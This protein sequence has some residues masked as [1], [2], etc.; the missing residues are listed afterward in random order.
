MCKGDGNEKC[1]TS[2]NDK[3]C[4]HNETTVKLDEVGDYIV[5]PSRF[6]HHGYYRIASNKTYYTAQLFCKVT[7][8]CKVWPNVTRKVSQNMIQG[9]VIELRLTQL[10]Q[11][12]RNNWDTMY[13]VNVFPPAKAFNGEKINATKNRHIPSVM[14]LGVPLIAELVKYFDDIY[15]HLKIRSVWIIE[16]SRENDGFQH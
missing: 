11:D 10:T 3:Q 14:F 12:I 15:T 16:K 13:S 9:P 2:S 6:Y 5:F 4:D 8:N 1:F 7:E